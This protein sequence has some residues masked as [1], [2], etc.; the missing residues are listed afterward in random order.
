MQQHFRRGLGAYP[1]RNRS[2]VA[3]LT[4]RDA[5]H[6]NPNVTIRGTGCAFA[7]SSTHAD[8]KTRKQALRDDRAGWTAAERAE[9]AN[10]AANGSWQLIDRSQVPHGRSL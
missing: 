10:H 5:R 1:L 6:R 3:L 2:P 8:P 4:V 7:I 9:I